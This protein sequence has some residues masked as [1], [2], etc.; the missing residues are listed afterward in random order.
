MSRLNR[1]GEEAR[2][3]HARGIVKSNEGLAHDICGISAPGY[4]SNQKG[5]QRATLFHEQIQEA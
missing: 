5:R 4:T 1:F 3:R 2:L